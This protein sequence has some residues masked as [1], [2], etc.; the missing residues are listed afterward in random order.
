MY[1]EMRI[2]Q[3]KDPVLYE[4][5]YT[6]FPIRKMMLHVLECAASHVSCR[7]SLKGY[8][9]IWDLS[10]IPEK[11]P[12]AVHIRFATNDRKVCSYYQALVK[13]KRN[14]MIKQL[15]ISA[16]DP[17]PFCMYISDKK[18]RE[19][20]A[21][22]FASYVPGE[23]ATLTVTAPET[24]QYAKLYNAEASILKAK[25]PYFEEMTIGGSEEV[26]KEFVKDFRKLP[27]YKSYIDRLGIDDKEALSITEDEYNDYLLTYQEICSRYRDDLS[28]SRILRT[29][30]IPFNKL[31]KAGKRIRKGEDIPEGAEE[32]KSMG[33][34]SA[35]LEAPGKQGEDKKDKR[36]KKDK[37]EKKAE[38]I[39][40]KE[41]PEK[42]EEAESSEKEA[43][44]SSYGGSLFSMMSM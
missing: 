25:Y 28:W 42:K 17:A 41:M 33:G 14:Q 38:P 2:Y 37:K 34:E 24:T 39:K 29:P 40:E 43:E 1:I 21:E 9:S 32:E 7:I 36:D 19:A 16:L 22:A 30:K 12:R 8:R 27:V 31:T 11:M 4:L 26:M 23:S 10:T 3:S 13:Y 15:V 20:A 6:G 18:E 35:P 44:T 5:Y